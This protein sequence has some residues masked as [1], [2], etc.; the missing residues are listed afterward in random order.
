MVLTLLLPWF[1]IALAVGVGGR[2]LGR[3]RGGGFG[4][5]CAVFWIVLIQASNGVAIWMDPWTTATILA[6]AVA[7]IAM[8]RWSGDVPDAESPHS[9]HPTGEA[10]SQPPSIHADVDAARVIADT[11]EQF[12]VWLDEHRDDANPWP[13]FD[14]FLRAMLRH[15]CQAR[16]VRAFRLVGEGHELAPLREIESAPLSG[17]LSARHG[18]LGHVVTSGRSYRADDDANGERLGELTGQMENSAAWCFAI[19]EG[20]R[21]LGVVSVGAVELDPRHRRQRLRAMERLV[22]QFWLTLREVSHGRRLA[23]LDPE[24]GILTRGAF[25]R[26]ATKAIE[27]SY[28]QCE[29]VVV[30]ILAIEGLRELNDAGR[31]D[32]ADDFLGL[33]C[34]EIRKKI[35]I[36][37]VLGRFDGSRLVLLLQR[38]DSELAS[39]IL[40]QTVSRLETLCRDGDRWPATVGIRA[41]LA[42]SGTEQP[43]LP[44]LLTRALA[45][46]SRARAE[47]LAVA[48]DVA[49]A[50]ASTKKVSL[51]GATG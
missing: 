17:R 33:C 23:Q 48:S 45:Q 12:D 25:F 19:R 13:D 26:D 15:G 5:L 22:H 29:P 32:A 16:H 11:I 21:R 18:L 38:V 44:T 27:S 50:D 40:R 36:D 42:G 3:T 41:G 4:A 24:C 37:D 43:D 7:I 49:V 2:L 31:W 28:R 9:V 6:G 30:A 39:L 46:G 47:R 8:G 10:G 35:R 51:A 34:Q 20:T 1:P 14:E